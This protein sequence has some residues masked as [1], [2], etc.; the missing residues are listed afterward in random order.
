V[1]GSYAVHSSTVGCWVQR[2][3][4]SGSGETELY[5]RLQSGHPATATSTDMLQHTDDIIHA[6]RR[7]INRQLAVQLSVSNGSA[8]EITD[9]LGYSKVCTRWVP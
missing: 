6:N 5:D 2:V 3:K 9:A 8:I 4:V 1:Y 7:I